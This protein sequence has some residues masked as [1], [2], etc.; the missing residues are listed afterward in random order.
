MI[1]IHRYHHLRALPLKAMR[2][3]DEWRKCVI[4]SY[5]FLLMF[6]MHMLPP[7]IDSITTLFCNEMGIHSQSNDI[8]CKCN[9]IVPHTMC[10]SSFI[11]PVWLDV[12]RLQLTS[13]ICLKMKFMLRNASPFFSSLHSAV[14]T[15]RS[16]LSFLVCVCWISN[17]T[18]TKN[19]ECVQWVQCTF[20]YKNSTK[21][22][23]LSLS[24]SL[25]F[26]SL[27]GNY[28]NMHSFV[29]Q[30]KNRR[31]KNP[32]EMEWEMFYEKKN[33]FWLH[34][35]LVTVSSPPPV[36]LSL[37]RSVIMYATHFRIKLI[38]FRMALRLL[39]PMTMK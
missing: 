12:T 21:S 11:F 17:T 37:S 6:G 10:R 20:S 1:Q 26:S 16:L 38:W 15:Y 39:N 7:S 22:V 5:F 8:N 29:E 34:P 24:L 30:N 28:I 27:H 33:V 4:F 9:A 31:Q 19:V 25:F 18:K 36:P 32:T 14:R 2:R 23:S 13:S 3:P 35:E